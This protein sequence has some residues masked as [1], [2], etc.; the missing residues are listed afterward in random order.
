MAELRNFQRTPKT[1]ADAYFWEYGSGGTRNYW[2]WNEE[3]SRLISAIGLDADPPRAA[4]AYA[5][6]SVSSYDAGVAC[7]DAKYAYWAMRPFQL[8]PTFK[9]L[10]PTANHP[11]YPSADGC[12][13][14]AA[15]ATLAYL[16]PPDAPALAAL[17][18][19]AGEAR[20]WAGVHFR[21]DVTAGLALG[22]AVGQRVVQRA[23]QDGAQ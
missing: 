3:T 18:N 22:R 15:A 14:M 6:E 16:S 10:F 23:Q 5:L 12:F 13:S 9:P 20:I 8:D 17:A 2:N 4:R 7:W 19:Q 21:S 1:N 11:G